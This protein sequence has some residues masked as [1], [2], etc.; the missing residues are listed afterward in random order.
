MKRYDSLLLD[1]DG[2]LLDFNRSEREALL[3][4]LERAGIPASQDVIHRY[5]EINDQQWKALERGE[6]TKAELKIRRFDLFFREIGI[7]NRPDPEA[8][9]QGYME[10][11]SEKGYLLPGVYPAVQRLAKKFRLYLI[12]NGTTFVQRRR[13]A[14]CGLAPYF[15]DVF[16]SDVL[17]VQKPDPRFFDEVFMRQPLL[18]RHRCLI[19][20]DSLTSDIRGGLNARIDTCWLAPEGKKAPE[21]CRPLF[22]ISSLDQLE[23]LL[24]A[25]QEE[26]EA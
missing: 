20:G 7:T 25:L 13:W 9:N 8:F 19:I 22:Q 18:E 17:G 11:L 26:R 2:T 6:T 5:H 21:N 10:C 16:I 1:A 23:E 15:Q 4:M 3:E 14:I 12:T 24:A